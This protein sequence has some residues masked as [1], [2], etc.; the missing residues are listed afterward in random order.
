MSF[1]KFLSTAL[2]AF[3]LSVMGEGSILISSS[4]SPFTDKIN[5][6]FKTLNHF[7]SKFFFMD[8]LFFIEGISFPLVVF[9]L[10][11]CGIFFTFKMGFVN[12]RLFRHSILLSLGLLDKGGEGKSGE[13]S[14][15][16]ALSS[17]LS[18]TVGLGN[19]AG[20]A[21]AISVG[22][23]GAVF[24]MLVMGFFG[25]SMKFTECSLALMFRKKKKDGKWMG[26]PMEYLK[27]GFTEK[28]FPRLGAFLA[29]AFA[30]A[31]IGGSFGGGVA[32][33]VNQ[34]LNA[35]SLSLPFLQ[36]FKW[37]YALLLMVLTGFV[38]IGGIKR[39][40]EVSGKIVPLM[41]CIYVL[42]AF[43]VLISHY[44]RIPAAF[45]SIFTSAFSF[46]AGLG[47]FFAVFITGL[48]RAAFSNEAGLGSSPIIHSAAKASHP[49]EEGA[50]A[51][52]E[53]FFD[54][55]VICMVT[56]LI[57]I[58]TGVYNNPEHAELLSQNKGA[59]LT[60]M[61]LMQAHSFFP[62]ILSCVVFLFAFST[63]ISW[64]YYGERCFSFLFGENRTIIYKLG[65]LL[66]IFLGA[67][68]AGPEILGFCDLMIL[69]MSLPNLIGVTLLSGRVKKSMRE[70]IQL[71]NKKG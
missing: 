1:F 57:I 43:A 66:V 29:G 51:L 35:I 25:M 63:I 15:F 62:Y 38:I 70:Y 8:V 19:I 47:G 55:I 53:P 71:L 37:L 31:C 12:I 69:S 28:G 50:V 52:L 17:A 9:V 33:Q 40:G 65:V 36:D 27:K 22:G 11:V 20:V 3:P 44:D 18:A 32:F 13:V 61:A 6:T 60:S 14:H 46:K 59:A 56:A 26:G 5:L 64:S 45:V 41:F 48:Q 4:S 58:V 42:M 67:V 23:P 68:A 10:F 2:S 24:W 34:S 7:L 16:R 39:I 30:I 21:I 49:V 54:T